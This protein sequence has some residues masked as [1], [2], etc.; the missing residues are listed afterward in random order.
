MGTCNFGPKVSCGRVDPVSCKTR[1]ADRNQLGSGPRPPVHLTPLDRIGPVDRV[2]VRVPSTCYIDLVS[3]TWY[4][5]LR[6]D[7]NTYHSSTISHVVYIV[8]SVQLIVYYT[9]K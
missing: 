2:P 7:V 3:A 4:V 6:R 5:L 1:V 8:C 9:G